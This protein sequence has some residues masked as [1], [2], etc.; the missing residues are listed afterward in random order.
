MTQRKDNELE[1][2]TCGVGCGILFW[3]CDEKNP[4]HQIPF[5]GNLTAIQISP[6]TGQYIAAGSASSELF[7]FELSGRCIAQGT[8]H[9][10]PITRLHWSPDEKQIVTLSEDCSVA[11]WNFYA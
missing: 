8:A 7:I 3:D 5:A 2:I 4:V 6:V 11:I 1:L 10:L 9:S